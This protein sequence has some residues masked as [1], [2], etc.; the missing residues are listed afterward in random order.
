[1]CL[2]DVVDASLVAVTSSNLFKFFFIQNSKFLCFGAK[3]FLV[4]K[5]ELSY[6]TNW[7]LPLN[8]KGRSA[9]ELWDGILVHSCL[10][11]L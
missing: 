1:M 7:Y 2:L 10:G 4:P 6:S 11:R 8:L 5:V 9:K 3:G